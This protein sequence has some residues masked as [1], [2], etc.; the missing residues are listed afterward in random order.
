MWCKCLCLDKNL[1]RLIFFL[2]WVLHVNWTDETTICM[3]EV[4]YFC[5]SKCFSTNMSTQFP[6]FS[7]NH[8]IDPKLTTYNYT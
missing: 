1:Y 3:E 2:F 8:V 4:V 6:G 7:T 5:I